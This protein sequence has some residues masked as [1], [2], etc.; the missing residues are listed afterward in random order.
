MSGFGGHYVI[1]RARDYLANSQRAIEIAR[2][3]NFFDIGGL[4]QGRLPVLK[5]FREGPP[6][7]RAQ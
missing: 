5:L 7:A 6:P 1:D 4:Q 2:Q 3:L